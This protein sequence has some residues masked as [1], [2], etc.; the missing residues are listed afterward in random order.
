MNQQELKDVACNAAYQLIKAL[1]QIKDEDFVDSVLC[2]V[3]SNDEIS[4]VELMYD[5]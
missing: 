2:A 5:E 4:L 3:S 1:G